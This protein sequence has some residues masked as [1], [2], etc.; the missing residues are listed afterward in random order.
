MKAG[1]ILTIVLIIWII[2]P[3]L[4]AYLAARKKRDINFWTLTSVI[5]PPALFFLVFLS[6]RDAPPKK[7]FAEEQSDHDN[8]FPNR[9]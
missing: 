9:D 2:A 6:I 7:M 1:E 5:F 4:A 8:F 3:L